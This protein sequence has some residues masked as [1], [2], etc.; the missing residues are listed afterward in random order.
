M[1]KYRK[2]ADPTTGLN[3]FVPVTTQK[4]NLATRLIRFV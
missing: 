4:Q 3:P 1:E 2:F